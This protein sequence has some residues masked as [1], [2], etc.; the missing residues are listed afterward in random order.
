MSRPRRVASA[1]MIW[2]MLPLPGSAS[3]S[4]LFRKSSSTSDLLGSL[5]VEAAGRSGESLK[6]LRP[7][8]PFLL[9]GAGPR[10]FGL[11]G[12]DDLPDLFGGCLLATAVV[13]SARAVAEGATLLQVHLRH[14]F[15]KPMARRDMSITAKKLLCDTSIL[16]T[17]PSLC[18]NATTVQCTHHSTVIKLQHALMLW[19]A[20]A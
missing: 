18:H 5:S 10:K 8:S 14:S 16:W 9:P 15:G 2:L 13:D 20:L 6:A 12:S 7:S 17:Y 11:M 19:L 3:S 1:A 4:T